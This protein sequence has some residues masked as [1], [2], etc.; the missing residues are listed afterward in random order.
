MLWQVLHWYVRKTDRPSETSFSS[1]PAVR[2]FG[3]WSL[4]LATLGVPVALTYLRRLPGQIRQAI[5]Q[6]D[7]APGR[8]GDSKNGAAVPLPRVSVPGPEQPV[9]PASNGDVARLPALTGNSGA[10]QGDGA[11]P[12]DGETANGS[13]APPS[14]DAVPSSER[15]AAPDKPVPEN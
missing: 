7:R 13:A 10:G 12:K 4:R 1:S 14:H 15:Q 5:R 11:P 9:Q 3:T 6:G 8:Q 2:R